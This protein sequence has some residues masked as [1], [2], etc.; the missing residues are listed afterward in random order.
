MKKD[1]KVKE[2]KKHHFG[3]TY[4]NLYQGNYYKQPQIITFC[5]HHMNNEINT[6]KLN[7]QRGQGD[8]Q[9]PHQWLSHYVPPSLYQEAKAH[10]MAGA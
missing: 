1:T 3:I 6:P 9:L 5:P 10:H 8:D 7:I 2:K 4:S